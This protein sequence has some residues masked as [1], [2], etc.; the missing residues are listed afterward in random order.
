MEAMKCRAV[1]LLVLVVLPSCATIDDKTTPTLEQHFTGLWQAQDYDPGATL[2]LHRGGKCILT[3]S[4]TS[5]KGTWSLTN[6]ELKVVIPPTPPFDFEE[7]SGFFN[8]QG[9]KLVFWA[10]EGEAVLFRK[11]SD[12]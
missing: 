10:Q 12:P 3:E 9:D 2:D 8:S 7:F 1:V 5:A 4:E 6:R 11:V